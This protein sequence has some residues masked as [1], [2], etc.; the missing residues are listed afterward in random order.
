M[1]K[2]NLNIFNNHFQILSESE[3]LINRIRL[4]FFHFIRNEVIHD[5]GQQIFLHI[6]DP[7]WEILP[8]IRSI[9]QTDTSII[10]EK[11]DIRYN[12]YHGKALTSVNTLTGQS[13]IYS[14]DL[15]LTH[16]LGYLLI[17]SKSGKQMDLNGFHKLH[18][19]GL[20]I[21][22][23]SVIMVAPSKGGK[24]TLF[25]QLLKN[26]GFQIYSDD[27][28]VIDRLGKIHAFPLRLGLESNSSIPEHIN[29]E[30]IYHLKRRNFGNKI[31]IPL[32]AFGRQIAISSK[33]DKVILL[34]ALRS[35]LKTPS[36]IPV[37]KL[38]IVPYI[39]KFMI[40]GLGLPM[41]LEYFLETGVRDIFKRI[42]IIL[43]RSCAAFFLILRSQTY[44]F[45]MSQNISLNEQVICNF[46]KS[47]KSDD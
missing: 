47:K 24:S 44:V 11:D 23:T 33:N 45:E 22:Q 7:P 20:K 2:L 10:Y 31:L 39:F 6:S 30:L 46:L 1:H 28:P 12:D 36:V 5:E 27:T 38:Q 41:I 29:P 35:R 25:M 18:A 3:E 32:N 16:E 4:D 40:I 42:K 17:L 34:I 26:P 14:P 9:Q 43:S 13:H 37:G 19:M 21:D 8:T 15:H